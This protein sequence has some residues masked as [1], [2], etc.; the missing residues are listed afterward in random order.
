MVGKSLANGLMAAE[1]E[2]LRLIYVLVMETGIFSMIANKTKDF[3]DKDVDHSKQKL[4]LEIAKLRNIDDNTLRLQLFLHMTKEFE[5]AGSYYN[6]SYEIENKCGEILQKAHAFQM[7][8]DKN[9]SAFVSRNEHL[10]IDNQLALYQMQKLFESIG[11][12]LKNLTADQEENFANQIEQFIESLPTEQQEKIK[13]KLNIDAVTNA[14]IK[15]L[16]A[17]QGSAVLLAV[18][19]EIAGFAAY[20]TLTSLIA[21]TASLIG[22]TLPFSAYITATSALSVLTGPVGFILIGGLSS[23]MM[24][25]QSKKVKR[26]LLQMGIVQLMLPVLLGDSKVYEYDAFIQEWSRFYNEQNKLLD[27]I[28]NYK[29]ECELITQQLKTKKESI[30]Y[31]DNQ[32]ME[33]TSVYNNIVNQLIDSLI[34]VSEHEKTESFK[35]KSMN[36]ANLE[37]E[38]RNKEESIRKNKQLDSFWGKV[39]GMLSN[40]SYESDISKIKKQIHELKREQAIEVISIRPIRLNK[41][42]NEAHFIMEEKRKVIE[43]LTKLKE[44]KREIEKNLSSVNSM[45][46]QKQDELRTLQKEVYGLGDIV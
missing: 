23:M 13:D 7:K 21:G 30:V 37:I 15:K 29:K 3:F 10:T 27:S 11:G 33:S 5:L 2:Q 9:Y 18:I 16:I 6:T 19:V 20:T 4:D 39:S 25:T 44:Q 26:T 28:A 35:Q 14:T 17:T 46:Y 42:C 38:V 8:K 45:L 43:K 12:E 24:L 34:L 41:I 1:G 36:I 32:L 31:C 40:V 22:L